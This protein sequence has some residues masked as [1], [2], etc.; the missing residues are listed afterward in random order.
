MEVPIYRAFGGEMKKEIVYLS[1]I[2]VLTKERK[3]V[4]GPATQQRPRV[5][6]AKEEFKEQKRD[7]K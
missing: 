5:S 2:L 4:K 1:H 6:C 3:L 7:S